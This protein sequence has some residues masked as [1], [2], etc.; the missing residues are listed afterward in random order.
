MQT[1]KQSLIE[2][3]TNI[4]IGYFVAISSQIVVFP[5]FDI[6]IPISDNLLIG[7]Y[8][9]IISMFR[10]YLVRRWYNSKQSPK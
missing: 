5:L 4:I 2:T 10:G 1:K 9:T 6:K 8:F 3:A 7:F